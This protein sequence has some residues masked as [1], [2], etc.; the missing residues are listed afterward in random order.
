M[1]CNTSI[2]WSNIE[3]IVESLRLNHR[4]MRNV[5][6]VSMLRFSELRRMIQELPDFSDD[7]S[8]NEK[9]LEAVQKGLLEGCEED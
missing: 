5:D 7:N 1:K 8:C 3:E 4:E 2:T 6:N 9:K